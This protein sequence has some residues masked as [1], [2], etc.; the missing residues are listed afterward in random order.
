MSSRNGLKRH[1]QPGGDVGAGLP[2]L[3][4][5]PTST[6]RLAAVAVAALFSLAITLN[7]LNNAFGNPLTCI[8]A[9]GALLAL[10]L[11]WPP[12]ARF[13][14]ARRGPVLLVAG[15]TCWALLPVAIPALGDNLLSGGLALSET[16]GIAAALC[17][18]LCGS[19][20]G[21]RRKNLRMAVDTLIL[22]GCLN[23]IFGVAMNS[24]G[25]A[26]PLDLWQ[27]RP[28]VRFT[29]TL[30]NANVA[31]AYFGMMAALA[32]ARVL[33]VRIGRGLEPREL[34][35]AGAYLVALTLLLE[36]CF[37]TGS[38][39][40]GAITVAVLL[41]LGVKAALQKE[42][43]SSQRIIVA[44][45]AIVLFLVMAAGIS[46][47]LVDRLDDAV[48]GD[49]SGRLVMWSHYADLALRSP[50]FGYGLGSFEA[51]NARYLGDP[52]LAQGLWMVNSAHD[53]VLQFVLDGGIVYFL[54]LAGAA[55]LVARSAVT[56]A[57]ALHWGHGSDGIIGAIGIVF[58][59]SMVDIALDVPG[60]ACLTTFLAGLL[61]M[62]DRTQGPRRAT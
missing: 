49:R 55:A 40:A 36:V 17:A 3:W 54:L 41:G 56:R 62:P 22:M 14:R 13:W 61:W 10:T 58:A 32:F 26:I 34:A 24:F 21:D 16:L 29:G 45:G 35:H 20:L 53:L 39:S 60:L 18:L 37:L 38:R 6:P 8:F 4:K 50:W 12:D 57:A 44:A 25:S 43:G 42:S 47:L 51:L 5:R 2:V 48:A 11:V 59:C 33:E 15:A 28:G 9:A 1:H 30:S 46:D 52:R 19:R 7:G 27:S 23:A 31:G